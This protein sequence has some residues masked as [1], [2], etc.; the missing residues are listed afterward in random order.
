M[1]TPKIDFS[2]WVYPVTGDVTSLSGWRSLSGGQI[3]GGI[4]I[5]CPYKTPVYSSCDGK[6]KRVGCQGYGIYT[7][8]IIVDEKYY[9]DEMK[10]QGIFMT[11]I[12]GHFNS[13]VVVADDLVT[14]GQKIGL[15][16]G[17]KGNPNE[18]ITTGPHLHYELRYYWPSST[19]TK[20]SY[21]FTRVVCNQLDGLF[22]KNISN[23]TSPQVNPSS[24]AKITSLTLMFDHTKQS[25][26]NET[27][28][29]AKFKEFYIYDVAGVIILPSFDFTPTGYYADYK[30][31]LPIGNSG[32]T[33]NGYIGTILAD[34][35]GEIKADLKVIYDGVEYWKVT[36]RTN[37][38][39]SN[40]Q[41]S[42]GGKLYNQVWVKRTSVRGSETFIP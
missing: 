6:V 7:P 11:I 20:K 22:N 19:G 41:I 2:T 33:G 29:A 40:L 8:E 34:N 28:K 15:S 21:T 25:S 9:S 12:Y 32:L 36:L 39:K 3:H 37:D 30:D 42:S 24:G 18:G 38:N 27:N 13:C 5:S 31:S 10:Q 23:L 16:G 14:N 26:A 1:I 4:D 35:A 17:K